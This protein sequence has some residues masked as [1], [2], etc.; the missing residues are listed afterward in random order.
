MTSTIAK[1]TGKTYL[2]M[3]SKLLG[4]YD[5]LLPFLWYDFDIDDMAVFHLRLDSRAA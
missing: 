1:V 2:C 4:K 5:V 3:Q